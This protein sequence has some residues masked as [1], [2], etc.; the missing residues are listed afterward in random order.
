MQYITMCLDS[1]NKLEQR[2]VRHNNGYCL[3]L[4]ATCVSTYTQVNFRP[5][6]TSES[7]KSYAQWDPTVHSF[8]WTHMY[9]R[10]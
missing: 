7:I 3:H 5:F 8:L 9:K 6:C 4:W 1:T 10:T 2:Y